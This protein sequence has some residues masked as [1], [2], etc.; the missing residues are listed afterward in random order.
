M[1]REP[2]QRPVTLEDIGREL[3]KGESLEVQLAMSTFIVKAKQAALENQQHDAADG[4]ID[5]ER[6]WI[7]K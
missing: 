4:V 7:I 2:K 3:V 1:K 5:F 6:G